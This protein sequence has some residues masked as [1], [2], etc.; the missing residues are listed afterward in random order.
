MKTLMATTED[1]RFKIKLS[2]Y[3]YNDQP[4]SRLGGRTPREMLTG[5]PPRQLLQFLRP[6]DQTQSNEFEEPDEE[7]FCKWTEYLNM[8]HCAHGLSELQRLNAI[9]LPKSTFEI[10]DIVL[11]LDPVL[12]LSKTKSAQAKGPYIVTAVS[13][14]TLSLRHCVAHHKTTRN[15]RFVTKM[16]FSP[17]QAE[18]I[19]LHEKRT[20]ENNTV[21]PFDILRA[22]NAL[23]QLNVNISE[24]L[25]AEPRYCLRKRQ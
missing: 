17:E 13:K 16:R 19:I 8:L 23:E 10:N 6:E 24:D 12:N 4:Q 5:V 14:Q 1:F 22:P 25:T 3:F 9:K 20:F 7:S 18:Q 2:A 11:I 15:G 21:E